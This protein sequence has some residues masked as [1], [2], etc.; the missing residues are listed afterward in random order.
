MARTEK[1]NNRFYI[2]LDIDSYLAQWFI[3]EQG[4]NNPVQLK[5]GCI[6]GAQN[7]VYN[8]G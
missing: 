2:Y 1:T 3:N 8:V 6:Y 5:R 4:G 7:E